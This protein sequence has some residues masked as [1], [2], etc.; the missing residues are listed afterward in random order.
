MR[1]HVADRA[2]A[3]P[4]PEDAPAFR[5]VIRGAEPGKVDDAY[6]EDLAEFAVPDH[7]LRLEIRREKPPKIGTPGQ[8]VAAPGR[9]DGACTFLTGHAQGFFHEHVLVRFEGLN[10][11]GHVQPHGRCDVDRVRRRLLQGL[12]QIGV[13]LGQVVFGRQRPGVI[14]YHVAYRHQ[15]RIRGA[16]QG[17]GHPLPGDIPGADQ[18]P[19]HVVHLPSQAYI[20]TGAHEGRPYITK[21]PRI[22]LSG[23]RAVN[24]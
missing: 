24:L 9:L 13:D 4:L 18:K 1:A 21:N 19:P 2:A 6:E 11:V 5:I 10:R 16:R 20:A 17:G 12:I 8:P 14:L 7:L 3:G 23:F 15:F 22:E